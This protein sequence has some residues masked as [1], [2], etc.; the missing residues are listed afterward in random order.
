M[1]G[2]RTGRGHNASLLLHEDSNQKVW[3]RGEG[4]GLTSCDPI[5]ISRRQIGPSMRSCV[6]ARIRA[7]DCG[8]FVWPPCC[9]GFMVVP[10]EV[11]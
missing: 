8:Q 10:H 7:G 6:L 2:L 9:A 3:R 5:S 4:W 11:P 1:L